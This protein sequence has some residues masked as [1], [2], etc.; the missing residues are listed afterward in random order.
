MAMKL[1]RLKSIGTSRIT[2]PPNM[3]SDENTV[4]LVSTCMMSLYLVTDQ[5]DP[6]MPSLV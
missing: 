5:N 1:G 6:Y 4:W 2:M 3:A